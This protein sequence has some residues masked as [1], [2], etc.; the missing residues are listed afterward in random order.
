MILSLIEICFQESGSADGE[1]Y[2][3]SFE[4]GG[5]GRQPKRWE[6][7]YFQAFNRQLRAG[8]ELPRNDR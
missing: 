1:R 5:S 4:E 3:P 7:G 2:S 6:I 8:F